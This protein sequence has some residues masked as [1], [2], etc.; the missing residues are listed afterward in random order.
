MQIELKLQKKQKEA[1]Q[2]SL[3]IPVLFYGGSRGGGKAQSVESKILTPRGFVKM[4]DISAGDKVITDKGVEAVVLRTHPQ[5]VRA[6]Y[7]VTFIDGSS[8]VVTL[9]HLWKFKITGRKHRWRIGTTEELINRLNIANSS[10]A[11]TRPNVQIPLFSGVEF[12]NKKLLRLSSIVEFGS[13]EAKCITLDNPDG[14]YITDDFIVTH[15]SYLVRAREIYRRLKY[16]NTKGLIIRKTYPELLSNHIRMFWK[17]YPMTKDWFKQSE[18]AIYW[19]NGSITEF[20]Y[21]K[22]TSD[23]YTYQGREYE[24]ISIDEITQ[25]EEIV[26]KMLRGS[27]RTTNKDIKPSMFLTGNPGGVGHGWAKRMFVDRDFTE[28]ERPEDF[29]FVQAKV[30]DNAALMDADPDYLKR[31]QDLPDELRRAWLEGDWDVFAGQVFDEFRREKH[32]TRRVVPKPQFPHFL[33]LDWGYS[34]RKSHRGAFAGLAA[35]LVKAKHDGQTFNRVIV[36]R[37]WYGKYKYPH[38]WAEKIYDERPVAKFRGGYADPAMFNTQTD[39]SKAISKLMQEKWTEL[40]GDKMWLTLK[41]GGRNRI[42]RVATI[43]NWLS[44]APDGLPYMLITEACPHLIRTLPLMVYDDHNVED[45]DTNLEDH[46]VDSLSYGLSAIRF[47]PLKLGGVGA[48][49]TKKKVLPEVM[50]ELDL[51]LFETTKS[52]GAKDWR[53]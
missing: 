35:A 36:Y 47:L 24:D 48:K 44:I 16:P 33:W 41:P 10:T 23:V 37:E 53:V 17:E 29:D 42:A 14:L 25:H 52:T 6:L 30:Y 21:L 12:K 2:A 11:T 43:H 32:V 45:I 50:H 9:D 26:F 22:G 19:P 8:T 7:K 34:G 4:G 27:N 49:P 13:G 38:E 1:F 20:S 51:E 3:K 15:N 31:L 46:L 28:D 5:G 40:N 39:G 18:K